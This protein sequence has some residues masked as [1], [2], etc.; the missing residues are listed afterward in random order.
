MKVKSK[1]ELKDLLDKDFAWRIKELSY[2]LS[3]V[4]TDK[5]T[6]LK[7]TLRTSVLLLYAHWEGFIKNASSYYLS[8]VKHQ[9]LT[10]KELNNCFVALSLK[11]KIKVFEATNK[12][13]VHTQFVDYIQTAEN[14]VAKIE[15]LNVIKTGSNLNSL[16]LKEIL[17]TIGM[18]YSPY[19]L[20]ANMIDEQLLNYRN[21]IA[22]GEYLMVDQK[23]YKL[24]HSEIFKMMRNIKT[25]IENAAALDLF[26][27]VP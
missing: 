17:T 12:A 15:D 21:T 7:T 9:K 27:V 23:E 16:I 2:I 18:D 19:E 8:Y 22:H 11:Q 26:K 5:D 1:N 14:L 6:I 25:E 10:Y 24:L 13:T 20:K 4:R 3:A